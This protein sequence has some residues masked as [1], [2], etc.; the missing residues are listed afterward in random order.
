MTER[1]KRTR[2]TRL[3]A[4]FAEFDIEG[5]AAK[6][7]LK[8]IQKK[9]PTCQIEDM[10][11]TINDLTEEMVRLSI[12]AK[13]DGEEDLLNQLESMTL[14][15]EPIGTKRRR[16]NGG[17][18]GMSATALIMYLLADAMR[19]GANIASDKFAQL[20]AG[21]MK[22]L[23][24]LSNKDGCT[25]IVLREYLGNKSMLFIQFYYIGSMVNEATPMLVITKLAEILPKLLPYVTKGVSAGF[26]SAIGYLVYHFANHYGDKLTATAN[27]KLNS[28]KVVLDTLE[29]A[30]SEDVVEQVTK[31][32]KEMVKKT[33]DLV[34]ELNK[35]PQMLTEKERI[36]LMNKIKREL[37]AIPEI[38]VS[39]IENV[40]MIDE[41][42]RQLEPE[43]TSIGG[44]RA[45]KTNTRRRKEKKSNKSKKQHK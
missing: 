25:E 26:I 40:I 32:S 18:T 11:N 43:K 30:K 19:E 9:N 39:E 15:D 28:L 6:V 14:R 16:M 29:N 27:G 44:K 13:N 24:F 20:L 34:D 12:T 5:D 23:D 31:K 33:K 38:R 37:T 8:K 10:K 22:V 36:E 35:T 42:R 4:K 45:K 7:L 41:L 17:M 1:T 3:P 21:S 2:E